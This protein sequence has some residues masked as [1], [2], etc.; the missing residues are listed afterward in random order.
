[1]RGE[2]PK[3]QIESHHVF[4]WCNW[5]V[6]DMKMVE[7]TLGAISPF[8]HGLYMISKGGILAGKPIPL[9]WNHPDLKG[10]PFNPLTI[11]GISIPFAMLTISN[12]LNM[13]SKMGMTLLAYTMC[14]GRFG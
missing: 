1:M 7:A 5:N 14:P 8:I 12:L 6:N 13:K 10:K 3:S 11:Q 9:L 2:T 4:E